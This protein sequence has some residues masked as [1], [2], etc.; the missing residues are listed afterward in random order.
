[1]P[2]NLFSRAEKLQSQV[3]DEIAQLQEQ[4]RRLKT[5]RNSLTP[6]A[7]FPVEV[8]TEI[9]LWLVQ[10]AD[11]HRP[12]LNT[13]D[14]I[15]V[16]HVCRYW[17]QAALQDPNL[18]SR[19][20]VRFPADILQVWLERSKHVPIDFED[21]GRA[22]S[23]DA[24][25]ALTGIMERIR[26]LD[27]SPSA[28]QVVQVFKSPAPKLES[29]II[30]ADPENIID[31]PPEWIRAHAYQLR[32]LQVCRLR[33]DWNNF[34]LRA[35][36]QKL[37]HLKIHEPVTLPNPNELATFLKIIG[38]Q[39]E[40][41][42]LIHV[43]SSRNWPN[44]DALLPSA[45]HFS[46]SSLKYLYISGP[47]IAREV[48]FISLIESYG[49]AEVRLELSVPGI[50]PVSQ[51]NRRTMP[52]IVNF[53][54]R[55]KPPFKFENLILMSSNH[56][57]HFR[58]TNFQVDFFG[59]HD[60]TS[61]VADLANLPMP[62]LKRFT[63]LTPRESIESP[64]SGSDLFHSLSR[65]GE[66][67]EIGLDKVTARSFLDHFTLFGLITNPVPFPALKRIVVETDLINFNVDAFQHT[68][69]IRKGNGHTLESLS[70]RNSENVPEGLANRLKHVV[71]RYCSF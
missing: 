49:E 45:S 64:F 50:T 38:D 55:R 12:F 28:G 24:N 14:W 30:S 39:L 10:W 48:S 4:I 15:T 35:H 5:Q 41:V 44:P 7:S 60:D 58:D 23:E 42:H 52:T 25:I 61:W 53:L 62:G 1:M 13:S 31:V 68:L 17:R 29:L 47:S 43:L 40:V 59:L 70:F 33:F 66:L 11:Y 27:V 57:V 21:P 34:L 71:T 51:C 69:E 8:L 36:W 54:A 18:W 46:L 56:M 63:I 67:S 19:I 22:L 20:P 6:I 37:T 16:T 3:D 26:N 2:S 65:L 9:F 32:I